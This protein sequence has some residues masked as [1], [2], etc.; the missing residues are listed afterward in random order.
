L[1]RVL[2]AGLAERR[3]LN[4]QNAI[5]LIGLILPGC[6][7]PQPAVESPPEA[8][9]VKADGLA[10][11]LEVEVRP[12]VV[13]FILHATNPTRTSVKLDFSSGQRFD[14]M[15]RAG[16]GTE[17]WRWSS[18]QMFTQALGTEL[19][20]GGGSLRYEAEWRPGNRSGTF[21]AIGRITAT[22]AQLEQRATFELTGN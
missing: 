5:L 1:G 6:S 21:T 3:Q 2:F 22:N 11:S 14:F 15:V 9:V 7:A 17:V 10:T 13:R 4:R 20:A 19:V 16:S 12:G 8:V 18:D